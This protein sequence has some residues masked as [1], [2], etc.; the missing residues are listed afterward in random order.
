MNQITNKEF[1]NSGYFVK[2]YKATEILSQTIK[3]FRVISKSSDDPLRVCLER[4]ISICQNHHH[5]NI[6]EYFGN[7]I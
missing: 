6:V 1:I 2:V 3:C 4:E 5:P 7:F